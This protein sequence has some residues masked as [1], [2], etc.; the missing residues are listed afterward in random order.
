MLFVAVLIFEASKN[1]VRSPDIHNVAYLVQVATLTEA[2]RE[3]EAVEF[4]KKQL[5]QQL[6]S[7]LRGMMRRDSALQNVSEPFL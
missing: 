4:E 7:A 5:Q 2:A 6:Q 3:M 1:G